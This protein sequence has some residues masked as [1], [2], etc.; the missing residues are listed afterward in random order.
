MSLL[1]LRCP[2]SPGMPLPVKKDEPLDP[3][4][5]LALG[6]SARLSTLNSLEP[7]DLADLLQQ[8]E[9]PIRNNPSRGRDAFLLPIYEPIFLIN[10][11]GRSL[12]KVS[13]SPHDA[14]QPV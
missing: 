2:H 10:T 4:L 9:L 5:I 11:Y 7:H 12:W 13:F 8:L 14:L 6:P 1:Q 3:L